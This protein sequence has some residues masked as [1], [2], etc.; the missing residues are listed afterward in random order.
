MLGTMWGRILVT[1]LTV[2]LELISLRF[3]FHDVL[4]WL[5]IWTQTLAKHVAHLFSRDPLVIF[6]GRIREI[7]DEHEVGED[8][9]PVMGLDPKL[10]VGWELNVNVSAFV[11]RTADTTL[12]GEGHRGC[13]PFRLGLSSG[14]EL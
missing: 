1:L 12:M 6:E 9:F 7:D 2:T 3:V 13:D 8:G 11:E 4:D 10:I 5:R 14:C